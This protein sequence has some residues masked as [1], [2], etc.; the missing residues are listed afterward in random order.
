LKETN[1]LRYEHDADAVILDSSLSAY[2]QT[3]LDGLDET[4]LA[5]VPTCWGPCSGDEN[6][7]CGS[8]AL[9]PL[10]TD[11]PEADKHWYVAAT[12]SDVP[13]CIAGNKILITTYKED[14]TTM[15]EK[16]RTAGRAT[17]QSYASEI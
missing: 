5:K 2:I 13:D 9:E 8:A 6:K 3:V 4:K 10:K 16:L 14:D 15:L 1:N 17:K 12:E 11:C 7:A